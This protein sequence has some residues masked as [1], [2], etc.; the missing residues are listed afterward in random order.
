[1]RICICFN[2]AADLPQP[3]I[4]KHRTQSGKNQ[5]EDERSPIQYATAGVDVGHPDILRNT[6]DGSLLFFDELY[7]R[8]P[9]L[10]Q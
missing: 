8:V 3:A 9:A 5:T 2:A 7:P 1:M 10:G 4:L 6:T